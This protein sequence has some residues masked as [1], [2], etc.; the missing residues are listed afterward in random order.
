MTFRPGE[1]PPAEV[2]VEL[3]GAQIGRFVPKQMWQT[4]SFMAKP[5]PVNGLSTLRF[6]TGTFNP[7]ELQ[8]SSDNRDLGFLLDEIK[9]NPAH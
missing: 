3:D 9:V 4:F 7:A 2:V 6:K 8:L 5:Q 1:I